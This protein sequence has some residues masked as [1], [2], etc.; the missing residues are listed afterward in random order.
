MLLLELIVST[1]SSIVTSAFGTFTPGLVKPM[2][3]IFDVVLD[4]AVKST[5]SNED[6]AAFLATNL[7]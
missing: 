6:D 2:P 1:S 7:L 5:A 3:L 4:F